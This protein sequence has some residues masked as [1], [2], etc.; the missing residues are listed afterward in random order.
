MPCLEILLCDFFDDMA[1]LRKVFRF[2]R[3]VEAL[4]DFFAALAS[5]R[6]S[7]GCRHALLEVDDCSVH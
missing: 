6:L 5:V 2:S 4:L 7:G 1:Q 3:A